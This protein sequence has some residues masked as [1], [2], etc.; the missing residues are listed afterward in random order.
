[1]FVRRLSY[2]IL[3]SVTTSLIVRIDWQH[4]TH[5]GQVV[6]VATHTTE[7][8]LIHPQPASTP[9][10]SPSHNLVHIIV[11]LVLEQ[12]RCG[13][14][15]QE[16]VDRIIS[17]MIDQIDSYESD[18]DLGSQ[19][20]S[21]HVGLNNADLNHAASSDARDSGDA[22]AIR[23][24]TGFTAHD[25]G[26][27]PPP[28]NPVYTRLLASLKCD[29]ARDQLEKVVQALED[30]RNV[31]PYAPHQLGPLLCALFPLRASSRERE[32]QHERSSSSFPTPTDGQQSVE[33]KHSWYYPPSRYDLE[34]LLPRTVD[35]GPVPA[36]FNQA[37]A[38]TD[39]VE[40][41]R[42]MLVEASRLESTASDAVDAGIVDAG[43][44]HADEA[45]ELDSD[46][47][48]GSDGSSAHTLAAGL[49]AP[50][51]LLDAKERTPKHSPGT[52]STSTR[53]LALV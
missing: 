38:Y 32:R 19:A 23:G 13:Q 4:D 28:R 22:S 50:P 7:D 47:S 6:H 1:M 37:L 15:P 53:Q 14:V 10:P 5:P 46:T 41:A 29:D 48:L 36:S 9:A 3:T 11:A 16:R 18:G 31:A 30:R 52:E 34:L 27:T 44:E 21:S 33:R 49:C 12:L 45:P 17:L 35:S 8:Q 40:L 42:A 2:G 43:I 26:R 24:D 39:D 25:N 51:V 20:N